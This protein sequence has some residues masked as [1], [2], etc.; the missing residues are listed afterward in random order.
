MRNLTTAKI[1]V[2]SLPDILVCFDN[3][4]LKI[5][6]TIVNKI[7]SNFIEILYESFFF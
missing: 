5:I 3:S 1:I 4:V 6:L 2:L 7:N